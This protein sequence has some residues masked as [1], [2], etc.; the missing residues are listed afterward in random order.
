MEDLQALNKRILAH[1][2]DGAGNVNLHSALNLITVCVGK[3]ALSPADIFSTLA[4]RA[5]GSHHE[6]P[7]D[8]TSLNKE[9]LLFA[10]QTSRDILN[11]Q[12]DG[13][14]TLNIDIN[15]ARVLARLSTQQ[16]TELSRHW[17]GLVFEVPPTATHKVPPMHTKAIPHYS[18][19]ILAAA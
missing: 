11:A 12:F 4:G 3:F 14:I 1:L 16:I 10:R 17:K 9:Y 8:V 19:A 5:G 7:L 6:N 13:L 2:G 15:Q 18:V